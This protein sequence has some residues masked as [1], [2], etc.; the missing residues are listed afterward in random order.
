M[1]TE[2]PP[3]GDNDQIISVREGIVVKEYTEKEA[4]KIMSEE[5]LSLLSSYHPGDYEKGIQVWGRGIRGA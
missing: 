1:T 5:G 2:N 3:R 4:A